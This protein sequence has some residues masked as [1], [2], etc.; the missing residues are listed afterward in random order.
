MPTTGSMVCRFITRLQRRPAMKFGLIAAS[1]LLLAAAC[2]PVAPS[3][4]ISDVQRACDVT[5]S[6]GSYAMGV[7]HELKTRILILVDQAVGLD[8]M[9]ERRWGREGESDL[10]IHAPAPGAA[11][12]LFEQIAALIP[13]TSDRAPTTVTHRDGRR[14]QSTWPDAS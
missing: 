5:V 4:P 9:E 1:A 10:C 6:F 3:G 2:A 13:A 12:R 7:D 14:D 8:N 11:D